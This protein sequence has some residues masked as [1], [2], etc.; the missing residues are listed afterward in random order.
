MSSYGC[1]MVSYMSKYVYM[2]KTLQRSTPPYE[3]LQS[4]SQESKALKT[5]LSVH[6]VDILNIGWQ[7]CINRFPITFRSQNAPFPYERAPPQGQSPC[8]GALQK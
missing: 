2:C 4:A 6:Q 5:V 8:N 3:T 1:Q 7:K